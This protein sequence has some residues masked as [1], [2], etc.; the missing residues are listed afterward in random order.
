MAKI[1]RLLIPILVLTG[2]YFG[3]KHLAVKEVVP[4]RKRNP[5]EIAEAES[6][7]LQ[8]V[9]YRVL[10]QSQ[11]LVQP[12]N[13]TSLTSRVNGRI[14]EIS[15]KFES[16]SFFD[17]NDIL[18]KLD[19]TDFRAARV[20]AEANLARAQAALA[21]E[22]ARAEQALLDWS[23]LGYE[24]EPT[25]L[26][27]RKPQLKEAVANVRAAEANLSEADRNLERTLVIA[28]YAG[29]VRTRLVGLGQSINPNTS[30]GD[31]FSTD[32]AEIRL[33][34]SARELEHV[35]LPNNPE[36]KHV[37]I[38]LQDALSDSS[39][40]SWQGSI[41][42]TEGILDQRSRKLF[43]IAR[44]DDPFG[45]EKK[46]ESPLRIGQPVRGTLEGELIPNVFIIPR[47][48][49]RNPNEVVLVNP[50][51]S[52]LI[53][54]K[55]T[56][57]WSDPDNVIVDEGLPEGHYL[58]TRRLVNSQNGTKVKIVSVEDAPKAA[59]NEKSKP[60]A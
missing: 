8:R 2:G 17:A 53:R 31:I 56:P 29:R 38:H 42:R 7:L 48:A 33:S 25:D 15:P 18:L 11:G 47:S 23:D 45:L 41:V 36:D 32:F 20:S 57:I 14:I 34:L 10:L 40:Q 54:Q 28:P 43:F 4:K 55:I 35:K 6:V 27:L 39:P 13:S 19:P 60:A 30:L 3:Y 44:V 37:P 58:V 22:E 59:S 12:H 46:T 5:P 9:D 21:Q 16:G 52:T 50:E 49:L 26:V 1:I 24:T 51:D